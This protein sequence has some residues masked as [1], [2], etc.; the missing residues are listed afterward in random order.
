MLLLSRKC[1]GQ[2]LVKGEAQKSPFLFNFLGGGLSQVRLFSKNSNM[3]PLNVIRSPVFTSSPCKSICLYYAPS[4]HIVDY[5][6]YAF[7]LDGGGYVM[8]GVQ[9]RPPL[10]Q[11]PSSGSAGCDPSC[12]NGLCAGVYSTH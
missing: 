11:T 1:W 5:F 10:W 3:G 4:L 12:H 6:R 8:G 9:R 2:L 7:W